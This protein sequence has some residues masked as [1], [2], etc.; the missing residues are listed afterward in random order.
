MTLSGTAGND[1]LIGFKGNSDVYFFGRKSGSDT[2]EEVYDADHRDT[3]AVVFDADVR[4]EDVTVRR[5]GRG[6]TCW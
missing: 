2:I 5:D 4:P 6:P 3:D 1:T